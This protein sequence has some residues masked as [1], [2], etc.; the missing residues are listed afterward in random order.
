MDIDSM[1]INVDDIYCSNGFMVLIESHLTHLRTYKATTV[2]VSDHQCYKYE[3]DLYGL[4]ADIGIAP[5]LH[6]II[7]RIN[8]YVSSADF[9]GLHARLLMPNLDEIGML[10]NIYMTQKM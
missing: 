7:A 1:S 2:T 4:L 9:N 6:H 10:K 8:G 5:Y 3:G